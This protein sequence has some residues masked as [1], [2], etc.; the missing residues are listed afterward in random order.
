M[1][2]AATPRPGSL[3]QSIDYHA[4]APVLVLAATALVVL[5]AD[6]FLPR[7]RRWWAMP[8]SM[9]GVLASLAV[10]LTLVGGEPRGTFCTPAAR[11]P[12]L[13]GGGAVPRSCSYVLDGFALLFQVLFLVV[14]V[15]VLL[16]SLSSVAESRLPPGEYH[17]LLLS[18][19]VGMLTIA[20][21][22]DLLMLVVAL[23]VV[24]L[25]AFVLAGFRR[26]DARSSEAALKFFLVSVLATAVTLFGMSLVYGLTGSVQLDR[27]AVALARPEARQ[28]ITSAAIVLVLVGFGFKISAAPFHF[29]APDTY[30]GAPVP[31]AAFLAVASKAAGF[32]GLLSLVLVAFRPYADVWGPVLAVLAAVS[33]TLG[34]LVA[35]RQ[36]HVVRLLAWSS[37]AQAGYILVP[38][39]V[40]ATARGR[41]D[42]LPD[43]VAA[44]L[45]YLGIYAV[46]NLGAF[47]CV[48]A[49]AH[50]LPRN[51]LADYRGLARSSPLLATAFAFFLFCLAGLPPGLAGLFAKVVVFRATIDGGVAWLAVVMAVNTVIALYYYLRLAASLFAGRDKEPVSRATESVAPTAPRAATA[52]AAASAPAGASALAGANATAAA[53]APAG[54]NAPGVPAEVGVA[55]AVCALAAVVIGFDPQLVL[56]VT[57]LSTFA[58]P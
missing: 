25:P 36:R 51:E 10:T 17:F 45:A 49:V 12:A 19:F 5:V 4:V 46:M 43:A 55:I 34:N 7:E 11:L 47:A 14:A 16:L 57:P 9:A 27:I 21:S 29:W 24:S 41:T 33:M 48:V 1:L 39:G 42:V 31:V 50:R 40:A 53:S 23:E 37:I 35:L 20:A 8:I 38:L 18:S 30:Q 2:T 15:I 44:T 52:P 3:M 13:A 32:A 56:Q 58:L 28:P 22:R 26:T 54:A 6:L